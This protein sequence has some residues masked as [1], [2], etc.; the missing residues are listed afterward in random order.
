MPTFFRLIR[1][2]KSPAEA[3]RR[4]GA[5][6]ALTLL[7][8][9]LGLGLA[10]LP[11]V[12]AR[13]Q[14]EA[15]S[16]ARQYHIAP[17]PLGSVLRQFA[18]QAGILLSAEGSP[19]FTQPSPGLTGNMGVPEG[20][21]ELLAGTGL[22]AFPQANC[23]AA[24]SYILRPATGEPRA[25]AP[26]PALPPSLPQLLPLIAVSASALAGYR[27]HAVSSAS[28]TETALRDLPQSVS[29][30]NRALIDDQAMLSMADAIRYLPG[31]GVA[32]GEGNRDSAV[33]RGTTSSADFFLD[34][35]RDD[36]QYYRDFYNIDSVE[37]LNGANGMLFGRG[38]AGGV[39]NRVSKQAEWAP[40]SDLT[41][42][43]ATHSGRRASADL[44]RV[45]APDLALR[46]NLMGE[47]AASFRQGVELRRSGT[48]PTL[49]WRA[50]GTSVEIGYEHYQDRRTTDRG[51]PAYL[52]R[53]LEVARDTY[54]GN[55][56]V[57]PSS[58]KIDALNLLVE[59]ELG[60]GV[61]LRNRGRYAD[62]DKFY[63]NLVPAGTDA[64]GENVRLIGYSSATRRRNLFNQTDLSW[65][66]AP[67]GLRHRFNTGLEL[68]RQSTDNFRTSGYF[69]SLGP[70]VREVYVPL[71]APVTT[72]PVQFRQQASDAANHGV[73]SVISLFLQDQI[74]L[75]AHWSALLGL[76]Y[77]RMEIDFL[78]Q[79][80]G[81]RLR[82]SERPLTPRAGLVWNAGPDL[83]L[84]A[85]ASLAYVPRAGEQLSS[86]TV[87]NAA[88]EPEKF[89]NLELGLKWDI[90][91][92]LSASAALYRLDRGN[93][94]VS[95]PDDSTR[96][97]LV[98]GQ[99]SDGLELSLS[100]AL[101]KDW[102]V[103]GAY[104]WQDARI[105]RS[106]S[107]TAL[108]GARLAQVPRHAFSL[109]SRHQLNDKTGAALGVVAR[110]QIFA[111]T[112]NLV[113]LPG[114]V[115]LDGALFYRLD[116]KSRL[117]L[118]LENLLDTHYFAS[119]HSDSN[120]MPGA[121]RALRLTVHSSF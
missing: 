21:L 43:L 36:V 73:A 99:R 104:T 47:R 9:G 70:D 19:T 40:R 60:G 101:Q 14:A 38:G 98:A 89:R 66:A 113:A 80:N 86:L 16:A 26:P 11:F 30:L 90:K 72:Q 41:L 96:S 15:G 56:A 120:L 95:D 103:V 27:T 76:R 69:T 48:N 79:R 75:S 31:V 54:F 61:L 8:V 49:A 39:I 4:H 22:A 57:S 7:G 115:R 1:F 78:N 17:G 83:S 82:Q 63:Q 65:N 59:H 51:L 2:V 97:L 81:Q 105:T 68:G 94:E 3:G 34:G 93:V 116:P 109:W 67:G 121:P 24:C 29:V 108:A 110:G 119:A 12:A 32:Q 52:G 6:L 71:G 112:S 100:G 46:L 117:Q 74:T 102:S 37:A 25:D 114:F 84:Y 118:N 107:A 88:L 55:P 62:Y 10:G 92:Q 5:R 28:R 87:S 23:K 44:N 111:S 53:P 13:A 42:S 77:E 18:A 20:L 106:L 45:L 85:S 58:V 50:A 64:G 35:I 33:F 91:P